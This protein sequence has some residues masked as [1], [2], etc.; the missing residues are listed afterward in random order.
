MGNQSSR[1][2]DALPPRGRPGWTSVP[3]RLATADVANFLPV[4][5]RGTWEQP[6]PP[7]RKGGIR[8]PLR[9]RGPQM[10]QPA[11]KEKLI[12]T[13]TR[14]PTL[15]PQ[16]PRG[17]G[18]SRRRRT[19]RLGTPERPCRRR[20]PEGSGSRPSSPAASPQTRGAVAY[21]AAREEA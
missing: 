13:T 1:G 14:A 8:E 2:C 16:R 11:L 18:Q 17:R 19:P 10:K 9:L 20:R 15:R 7:L 6:S 3:I 12:N 5:Q 21:P 4:R